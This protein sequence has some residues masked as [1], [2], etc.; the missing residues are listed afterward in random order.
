MLWQL[1][2]D[3]TI[4]YRKEYFDAM[5]ELTGCDRA[6]VLVRVDRNAPLFKMG[7]QTAIFKELDELPDVLQELVNKTINTFNATVPFIFLVIC[8]A[9]Y[10]I[11]RHLHKDVSGVSSLQPIVVISD[12]PVH[13]VTFGNNTVTLSSNRALLNTREWHWVEPQETATIWVSLLGAKF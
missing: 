6:L 5:E 9:G 3:P 13:G 2:N 10:E 11:Q 1:S 7:H 4:P 8:G 12:T